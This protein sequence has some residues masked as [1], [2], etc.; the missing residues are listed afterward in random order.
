[1]S[2]HEITRILG[3]SRNTVK[4]IIKNG[5]ALNIA[6][7]SDAIVV[8]DEILTQ[9]YKDCS[10]WRE[11]MWE[12]LTDEHKVDIGY[13]T[14]TRKV[15]ELGLGVKPR[16]THV[17]DVPGGEMQHDTSP[18]RIKVGGQMVLVVTVTLY[19][20]YSKQIYI[21]FYRA[22]NRFR[23]KC[24]IHEA[25][26]FYGYSAPECIIDNTNL[27]VL[28]GTGKDAVMHPEMEIFARRYGFRFVAHELRHSNRK[29]GEERG[30]WT[31]ETNFF[32]GRTFASMEDLNVQGHRW[33][34]ETRANK[35]RAKSQL[36][37]AK[38][39][40]HETAF[41]APVP[42]EMPAPYL[43]HDRRIDQYGFVAF[44]SNYYWLP[45]GAIGMAKVL[46][47]A[48]EIKI[49]QGRRLL[50][51]YALPVEGTKNKI[52]PADRPHGYQPRHTE[53]RS[54]D[55]EALLRNHS[56]DLSAYL[57]FILKGQGA[58]RHRMIRQL[59]GLYRRLSP[60][61]LD[62]VIARAHRYRVEDLRSLDEIA[63]L[64]ARDD[65]EFIPDVT[66]DHSYE[67]RHEYLEGRFTDP[68]EIESYEHMT[69]DSD[70]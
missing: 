69:G 30:F 28:R 59:H 2:K 12:K 4:S 48:N 66:C 14:M 16:A 37:P 21:R 60:A 19:F 56:A 18:H 31:V 52:F 61:L 35:M 17:G 36:I 7:R 11:R 58:L 8:S 55:E 39:F 25:L 32:P 70:E 41:L 68:P 6:P 29:A 34:T 65:A 26:T 63:R 33:A 40:E 54:G 51:A 20:R 43:P 9:L 45:S 67:E 27:A 50:A 1:M 10:G 42:A 49:Y 23:M 38:A 57:D 24:F 13:S 15:R 44:D 64:L 22:F 5:A 46:Q 3:V 62:R 47:Y 53:N